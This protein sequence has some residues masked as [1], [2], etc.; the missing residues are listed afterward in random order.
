MNDNTPLGGELDRAI[1]SVA[2]LIDQ[3]PLFRARARDVAATFGPQ[4]LDDLRQRF[5]RATPAPIGF[6]AKERGLTGWLSSWQ[7][8]LFEI[9]F[10]YREGAVSMLREVAFGEYDWTQSNAIE[11]LCRLAAEGI[12]R[13]RTLADL[14][15]EL[16]H[17]R[18]TA[19][20]YVAE[21]LMHRVPEDARLAAIFE[22]LQEVPEF[23]MTVQDMQQSGHPAQ[24]CSS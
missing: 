22:E 12:D 4:A 21:P 3:P 1:E 14:K 19:L 11:L 5:H 9:I 2:I 13:D 24:L 8:A 18:D 10:Q 15:R 7:F 16:P 6:T 17:M 23:R 20:M